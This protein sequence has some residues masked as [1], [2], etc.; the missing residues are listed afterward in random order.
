MEAAT[1]ALPNVRRYPLAVGELNGKV[2][3]HI[4]YGTTGDNPLYEGASSL[5]PTSDFM[6]IHYQGPHVTVDSVILDDWCKDH[7]VDHI[8]L[9]WLDLEGYEVQMLKSSP[10]ILSKVKVIYTETNFR[11]FRVEMTQYN[12]LKTFL[13]ESGFKLIAHWYAPTFQG[14]AIFVRM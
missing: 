13:E 5:L 14:D 10:K 1:A 4:C 2:T 6:A 8:D 7:S 9:M 3:F 12:N 11:E